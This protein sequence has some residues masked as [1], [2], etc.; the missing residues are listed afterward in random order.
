MTNEDSQPLQSP[1]DGR[2]NH[3]VPG[4]ET[5]ER[6]GPYRVSRYIGGGG[7]GDVWLATDEHGNDVAIKLLS[8]ARLGQNSAVERFMREGRTLSRLQHRNICH[9]Y[10]IESNGG[11]HYLVMEFVKGAAL[12]RLLHY[13]S[14]PSSD[15]TTRS[16]RTAREELSTIIEEVEQSTSAD[17]DWG[18]ARPV[19]TTEPSH[20]LPLQQTL[21]I[22][23]KLCDAVQYA[24]E[25]GVFHR[26]IKPSNVIIR[27]DGEPVLLDF[28]VA[29][30]ADEADLT[31]PGQLFGTM[32]YMAPEQAHSPMEV[33]ERA[34][35]YSIGAILYEM[36]VGQRHF[37]P[38]GNNLRDARRLAD[39]V[40][41][42]PRSLN[43][44]IDR[45]LQEIIV[46]ALSPDPALRYRS[47]RQLGDDL[48]RYREGKPIAARRPTLVYRLRTLTRKHAAA[49]TLWSVIVL[50]GGTLGGYYAIDYHRQW[51]DWK[52]VYSEDFTDGSYNASRL[53]FRQRNRRPASP[54]VSDS[55]G[56]SV[57]ETEWCWL[58]GAS[59]AG[60]VR[61]LIRLRF[62]AQLDGFEVLV[63]GADDTLPVWY[64]LPRGYSCQIGGYNGTLDIVS[65]NESPGMARMTHT[66][67]SHV[68]SGRGVLLQFQRV[69]S[70]AE[71][72]I[73]GRRQIRVE[74]PTPLWGAPF[75]RIGFRSY[76]RGVTVQSIEVY[77][78]SLPQHATPLVV[79][80]ALLA[81]G[82]HG[83][84]IDS[85]LGVAADFA[86]SPLAEQA[87]VSAALAAADMHGDT[88]RRMIDSLLGV[89]EEHFPGSDGWRLVRER[90][91][92]R[93]WR[94]GRY[95]KVLA[96]LPDHYRYYP[97]TR[98]GVVLLSMSTRGSLPRGIRETAFGWAA[99]T[100]D[101]AALDCSGLPPPVMRHLTGSSVR[102][103]N[104]SQMGLTDL[105]AVGGLQLH[106]LMCYGNRI[107]TLEPLRGQPLQYLVCHSN[108]LA[109]LDGL[110][111]APLRKL[112]ASGNEIENVWAIQ[113]APVTE[114]S[115]NG[116][117]IHDLAPLAGMPLAELRID[118]NL[119]TDL[120]P[121]RGTDLMA[122]MCR[123]NRIRDLAPLSGMPLARLGCGGNQGLDLRA[124]RTLPLSFLDC[125]SIGLATLDM[126][127]GLPLKVLSCSRNGLSDLSALRGMPLQSLACRRNVITSLASLR[128][129]QLEHLDIDGNRVASL[130]PLEGMPL[131]SVSCRDNPL[132]SFGPLLHNPPAQFDFIGDHVADTLLRRAIETWSDTPRHHHH[133]RQARICLLI[134]TGRHAELRGLGYRFEANTYLYVPKVVSWEEADSLARLSNG[135]LLTLSGKEETRYCASIK[136]AL[137]PVWL[138]ARHSH[139][140]ARTVTGESPG[141]LTQ[142]GGRDDGDWVLREE[143]ELW[144]PDRKCSFIIEW[145]G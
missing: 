65:V 78:M 44:R 126:L 142:F 110:Q 89:L 132:Q 57:V 91:M 74:D 50:L 144:P 133:L 66:A 5:P 96:L 94:D 71:L 98:I 72:I 54:W 138:G 145:E 83:D 115:L 24:H 122:L 107:E 120:E 80:D 39:H 28:G 77:R 102:N 22:I 85:Y 16:S 37:I 20:I 130:G 52:Q 17:G 69:G 68:Q 105:D 7:M 62:A 93:Q 139:G 117:R 51:G 12:S 31:M 19:V 121:L 3:P 141:Y 6:I 10:G 143:P 92:E 108:Q 8:I 95:E 104:C 21:S 41:V 38:S 99:R 131:R 43:R 118:D 58:D 61:V 63:N 9:I 79:G 82:F 84:A 64:A 75:E 49:L 26:D 100:R 101:V 87:I 42:R 48:C 114:L 45:E 106:W 135:H 60:D 11:R 53:R 46:K 127:R 88:A 128:G 111:G 55:N 119:V 4:H 97:C 32:E 67:A 47:A 73:D 113:G 129:L 15:E 109:G 36:C 59:V 123:R 56:L 124:V 90:E 1:P 27:R 136:D 76:A 14:A 103:L 25:R 134:N 2:V 33:D 137:R 18:A 13:L 112:E 125:D 35:V 86:S 70:A 34:D 81:Q 23:T 29:K 40:P 140:K 30:L 116:N